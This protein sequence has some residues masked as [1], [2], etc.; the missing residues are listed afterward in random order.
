MFSLSTDTDT[1]GCPGMNECI[2][3]MPFEPRKRRR[4]A[5]NLSIIPASRRTRG[6]IICRKDC[7]HMYCQWSTTTDMEHR[8]I[9]E[10]WPGSGS[11]SGSGPILSRDL[12]LDSLSLPTL[13]VTARRPPGIADQARV[14]TFSPLALT[15][16]HLHHLRRRRR[17]RRTRSAGRCADASGPWRPCCRCPRQSPSRHGEFSKRGRVYVPAAGRFRRRPCRRGSRR[18]R[19]RPGL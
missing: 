8:R 19:R 5:H 13:R 18:P 2:Q 12:F 16:H 1:Y 4:P 9:L 11:G 14:I 10:A 7:S 15:H 17:S 3:T 6:F